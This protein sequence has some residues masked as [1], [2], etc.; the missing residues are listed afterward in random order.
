MNVGVE[1]EKG[2]LVEVKLA[3]GLRIKDDAC[4]NN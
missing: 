2:E 1:F 3:K 4:K